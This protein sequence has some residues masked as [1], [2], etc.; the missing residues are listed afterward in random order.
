M[1]SSNIISTDIAKLLHNVTGF[2]RST[3]T[4]SKLESRATIV[5]DREYVPENYD[6]EKPTRPQVHRSNF[7]ECNVAQTVDYIDCS[8]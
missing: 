5:P 4:Y 3:R 2:L 7:C 8:A 1:Q 6:S